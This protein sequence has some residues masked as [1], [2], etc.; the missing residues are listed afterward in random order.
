MIH[1]IP[2]CGFACSYII[3]GDEGL[4]VVDVSSIGTAEDVVAYINDTPGMKLDDIRYITATHFHIDHI[5]GI[6]HLLRQ[7]PPETMVLFH[8][9]VEG[10][11]TGTRHISLIR[12]WCVGLVPASLASTR[13][14]RRFSHLKFESLAG[15]PLPGLRRIV[16]V[17]Y[18]QN[19][20]RYLGDGKYTRY[21]IGFD[22][23]EIIETP[24]HT[25]DSVSF[26]SE[27]S[28][29]LIS[30]DLILNMEKNGCG[31]LNRFHWSREVII[32]TYHVLCNTIKPKVIYPG[33]GEIIKSNENALLKVKTFT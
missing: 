1:T 5:G 23:W 32:K 20:I 9:F 14:I 31:R 10:Y 12:N 21:P 3:S 13:Y 7:C 11:L 15:I 26:Y 8:H 19:K 24:G 22:D 4:M 30:G 27:A 6:G 17:P 16:N 28:G 33:H 2:N 25:E 18:E 29:E